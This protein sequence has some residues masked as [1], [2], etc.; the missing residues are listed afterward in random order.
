MDSY[1]NLRDVASAI[2]YKCYLTYGGIVGSTFAC[3]KVGRDFAAMPQNSRCI[4]DRKKRTTEGRPYTPIPRRCVNI[5]DIASAI[6]YNLSNLVRHFAGRRKRHPLRIRSDLTTPNSSFLIVKPPPPHLYEKRLFF[7]LKNA[8]NRRF[9]DRGR[10]CI[11][12]FKKIAK[13]G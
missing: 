2:P 4:S 13:I 10:R 11:G 8:P 9:W 7:A 6:P 5:R 12:K 3:G 1:R